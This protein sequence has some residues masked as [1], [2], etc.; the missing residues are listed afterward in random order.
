MKEHVDLKMIRD[1]DRENAIA[2]ANPHVK[3]RIDLKEIKAS[4]ET[5]I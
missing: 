3:E 4:K 5:L 1:S 2:S